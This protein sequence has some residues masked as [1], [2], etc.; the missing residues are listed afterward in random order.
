M[1]PKWC[2]PPGCRL[3]SPGLCSMGSQAVR[4]LLAFIVSCF[5]HGLWH[6]IAMRACSTST[7]LL[8]CCS[9][10]FRHVVLALVVPFTNG[11]PS[12]HLQP[13]SVRHD[14]W[15][16]SCP[17]L[18]MVCGLPLQCMLAPRPHVCCCVAPRSQH[19]VLPLGVSFTNVLS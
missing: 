17:A 11:S 3:R 13:V 10:C 19:V 4:I 7:S 5:V 2:V 1:L 12:L 8:L 18:C 9:T 16:R 14:A 15:S 6:G